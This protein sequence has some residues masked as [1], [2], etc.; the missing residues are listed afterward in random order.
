M[1]T[2]KKASQTLVNSPFS[3]NIRGPETFRLASCP[4]FRHAEV[5]ILETGGRRSRPNYRSF[6]RGFFC[7]RP[8][9]CRQAFAA[10]CIE[11]QPSGGEERE[12]ACDLLVGSRM[13]EKPIRNASQ[14]DPFFNSA[15]VAIASRVS[16]DELM[17]GCRP[18]NCSRRNADDPRHWR[19]LV[20]H[21]LDCLY[22]PRRPHAGR[23]GS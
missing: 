18:T 6:F 17:S 10:T 22:T 2:G 11:G 3:Y 16:V 20:P 23:R 19:S 5:R 14:H 9:V 12:I 7:A 8:A 13:T 1:A 21:G 4:R 15:G